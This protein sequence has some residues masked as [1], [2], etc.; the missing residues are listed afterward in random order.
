MPYVIKH[1]CCYNNTVHFPHTHTATTL[2]CSVGWWWSIWSF[3]SRWHITGAHGHVVTILQ[4]AWVSMAIVGPLLSSSLSL[5]LLVLVVC[6]LCWSV[7][8][9]FFFVLGCLVLSLL[10]RMANGWCLLNRT[11]NTPFCINNP[12][13][14]AC[15]DKH[16]SEEWSE[17]TS[18][19]ATL[20]AQKRSSRP[21]WPL[22]RTGGH[23]SEAH[24]ATLF[25]GVH[26]FSLSDW[27]T[28]AYVPALYGMLLGDMS[29]WT[30]ASYAHNFETGWVPR[31]LFMVICQSV[32]GPIEIA[33]HW[34]EN[35]AQY[36]DPRDQEIRQAY[37]LS[38]K[39]EN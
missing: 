19:S 36:L 24:T 5:A 18:C 32:Y 22:T 15:L 10:S 13:C 1:A 23:N 21:C 39:K 9:V 17:K 6:C 11:N 34:K 12:T 3:I 25:F 26:C 28:L 7:R 33:F 14:Q 38:L 37:K 2:S 35:G 16:H 4:L 8:N 20:C 27:A 29:G 31:S 30:K